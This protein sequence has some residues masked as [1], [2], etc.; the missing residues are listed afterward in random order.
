MESYNL[1]TRQTKI[2]VS[3]MKGFC[4]TY[5]YVDLSDGKKICLACYAT[6]LFDA[7]NGEPINTHFTM[8]KGKC[9]HNHMNCFVSGP[10]TLYFLYDVD[11]LKLLDI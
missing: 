1:V 3:R 5:G 11:S 6:G 4:L 10:R 7:D 2:P 9:Y 8:T